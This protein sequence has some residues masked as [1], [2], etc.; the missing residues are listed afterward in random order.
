MR[1]VLLMSL[2]LVTNVFVELDIQGMEL[3]AK[4]RLMTLF[5]VKDEW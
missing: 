3:S 1:N 2:E 4:V 5:K